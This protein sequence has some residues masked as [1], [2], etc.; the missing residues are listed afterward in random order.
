MGK[1]GGVTRRSFLRGG[2]RLLRR[3]LLSVFAAEDG[4]NAHVETREAIP[5]EDWQSPYFGVHSGRR[6]VFLDC[7]GSIYY[8]IGCM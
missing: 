1:D 7:A 6:L 3:R 8:Q 2:W 4:A 5:I